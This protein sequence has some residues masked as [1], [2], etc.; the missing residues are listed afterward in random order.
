MTNRTYF[1]L[2]VEDEPAIRNGVLGTLKVWAAD[3]PDLWHF[4]AASNGVEGLEIA[5]SKP[6]DLLI[7]DI[8]MP[9]LSGIEMME[10]LREEN[11]EAPAILL[12][13]YAE[14][15][16]ARKALTL[17]AVNYLLKPVDQLQLIQAVEQALESGKIGSRRSR[18]DVHPAMRNETI[19]KALTY[20]A[21]H[22]ADPKLSLKKLADHVHLNPSYVSV[23]FKEET[24][25]TFSDYLNQQ[26]LIMAKRLLLGTDKKIYEIA[27]ETGFSASKYFIKVFRETEGITPREYRAIRKKIALETGEEAQR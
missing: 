7:S 11:R 13:G 4:G 20:I 14:F 3:Q 21:D 23:L 25:K 22:L 1:M 12:T 5:R 16:Y 26:R 10:K 6:V 18:E 9:G 15:E 27:D 2:I 17:G 19:R 24:G 8:R